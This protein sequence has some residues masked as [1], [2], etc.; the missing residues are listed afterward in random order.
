MGV[1]LLYILWSTGYWRLCALV[2]EAG[3]PFP[4]QQ[5]GNRSSR[6]P[7]HSEERYVYE[8]AIRQ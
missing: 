2:V 8:H 1:F 7:K 3:V 4:P 6:A 5:D